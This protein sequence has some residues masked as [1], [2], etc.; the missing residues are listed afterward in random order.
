[1]LLWL[2]LAT[3]SPADFMDLNE[4]SIKFQQFFPGAVDPMIT[5]APLSKHLDK[6]LN[7]NV[8]MD[9]LTYGYW[10]N[11]VHSQTDQYQFRKV[12]WEFEFGAHV[13]SKLDVYYSHWSQHWLDYYSTEAFPRQDGVGIRLYLYKKDH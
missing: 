5:N 1:M 13:G 6:E 4:A 8:N 10:N 3:A 7:L 12:G 11:T 9:V 2:F